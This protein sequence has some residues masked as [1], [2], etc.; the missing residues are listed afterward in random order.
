MIYLDNAAT[1][2]HK[3]PQVG[4]AMLEALQTAGNPGRGAHEPN[5]GRGGHRLALRAGRVVEHCREEAA[6]LLGVHHPERILFTANCT[7]ALNLAI[8]GTLRRGD[9]VICSYA[10]HNA[11]MRLLDR[12]V[13]RGEITVHMLAP[14]ERGILSP[15]SLRR[16]ISRKT[17]LVIIA[18][19]SNVTG[20]I[21]P[22]AQLGAVCR[23]RG[24][25][26]LVDAAQTAGMADVSPDVL[27]ADMV[28]MP[29]HKG[30]LGPQGTGLLVLGYGMSPEPLLLGGTGS[31]SESVRQPDMLPDRYESGTVNLPGIAGLYAGLKFVRAHR[32]EIEEYELALCDRLRAR[33][34]EI[35]G[36]RILCD[37]GQA[38]MAITS[39]VVPG[40]DGGALADALDAADIA[41]RAGLHCAPAVHAWLGTLQSG[42]IRF[43][44]GLYNTAQ[45]MD[46]TA[47]LLARLLQA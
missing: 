8:S 35:P 16:V 9:E 32:A 36:V 40:H 46:D 1:T 15:A 12:Y 17:A 26:L 13:S 21:Q 10:E 3:P 4:Q 43:S 2:L 25:P 22:I 33:L 29:G 47:L 23:E 24:V 6:R 31:M 28:A 5:P 7:E 44:P 27:C 11:V 38:H 41:V 14:D 20:L 30:L 37:D 42:A 34:R 18:H 45:E 39:I 19:A